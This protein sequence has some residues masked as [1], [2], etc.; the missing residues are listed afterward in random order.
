MIHLARMNDESFEAYLKRAIPSYASG[1]KQAEGLNDAD[2]LSLAN[3]SYKNLLPLGKDT[4]DHHLFE[5][6]ENSTSVQ[7]GILWFGIM[8]AGNARSAYV[9][10]LLIFDDYQGKG[11]GKQTMRLAEEEARKLGIH[12]V[13]L[14]VFAFNERARG[15]YTQLGYEITGYHMRKVLP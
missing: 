6:I 12:R 7:V 3:K 4:P 11:Y 2:A 5:V 9:Y 10:D 15:L 1:K 14:H 13:G 8:V